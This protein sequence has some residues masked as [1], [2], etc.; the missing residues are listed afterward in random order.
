MP[1]RKI[2]PNRRSLT[3]MVAS[4]KN[5]RMI[6]SES[7]LERD[8]LVRL[9]FDPVVER[10]E[11][12]P[13]CI[14]Y[15]D[16]EGHQ[17]TYT[18]D[19]LVYYRVDILPGWSPLLCEVKYR[20]EL[21]DKWKEIKPKVRAGRSY[22]R[23]QGW[24]F[25]IF[26]ERE[27][28]TPY[29]ENAKFLRSYRRVAVDEAQARLILDALSESI[30]SDP[31]QLLTRIHQDPSKRAALLPT[32]WRLVSDGHIGIDLSQPLTMRHRLWDI[33]QRSKEAIASEHLPHHYRAWVKD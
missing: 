8:L 28:R 26:T 9:E 12:Q 27:I 22:A 24:R 1:V 4:R 19:V 5:K 2:P 11:E 15:S 33:Q 20:A 31:D 7:S 10:Y 29:L 23:Q 21:F 17:R 18:P 14:Q 16:G 6:A 13:V 25:K 3:G 30:E 32:L